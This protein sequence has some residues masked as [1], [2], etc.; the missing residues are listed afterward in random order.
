MLMKPQVHF[1]M[2]VQDFLLTKCH[3]SL[4]SVLSELTKSVLM[5]TLACEQVLYF[6]VRKCQPIKMLIRLFSHVK[7]Y[8][9][10]NQNARTTFRM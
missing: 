2:V 4:S 9:T 8:H 1:F 5:F 7:K 6:W 3:K 10:T